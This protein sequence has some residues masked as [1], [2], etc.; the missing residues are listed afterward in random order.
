M[1]SACL[2]LLLLLLQEL[3]N[4]SCEGGKHPDVK[5]ALD[6]MLEKL[7]DQMRGCEYDV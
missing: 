6:T 3:G 4:P 5:K 7:A 1:P 2:I